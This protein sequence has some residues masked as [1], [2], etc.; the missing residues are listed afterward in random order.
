MLQNLFSKIGPWAVVLSVALVIF[1]G[2]TLLWYRIDDAITE[3]QREVK[4][5]AKENSIQ[6]ERDHRNANEK[7]SDDNKI[8]SDAN[9]VK[10]PDVDDVDKTDGHPPTTLKPPDGLIAPPGVLPD[11]PYK[12]MTLEEVKLL[13]ERK[14]KHTEKF[15]A[16][17]DKVMMATDILRENGKNEHLLVLSVLRKF[18]DEQLDHIQQKLSETMPKSDVDSFFNDLH[19]NGI[20]KTQNQLS[21]DAERILDSNQTYKIMKRE[22]AIE[23]AELKQEYREL[24]GDEAYNEVYGDE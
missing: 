13:E 18:S 12:G 1:V 24:Y 20:E 17:H 21:V 14:R 19:I 16:H 4:A 23:Y 10:T 22:L 7:V 8:D 6:V 2:G 9:T 3:R 5:D 11:G 15:S